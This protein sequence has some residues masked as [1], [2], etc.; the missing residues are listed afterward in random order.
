MQSS[1]KYRVQ[2]GFTSKLSGTIEHTSQMA[3]VISTVCLKQRSLVI[4][5][6][7]LKDAF[8]EVH[9]NLILEEFKFHHIP[10]YIKVPV[11]SL[12]NNFQ[13]SMITP[14]FKSPFL[15]VDQ[16]VLSPNLSV[17]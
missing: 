1:K 10:N 16:G 13:T 4:T 2:R 6:L 17:R 11:R 3:N 5:L 9:Q 15:H 7:D 12:Y 14:Q 8:G